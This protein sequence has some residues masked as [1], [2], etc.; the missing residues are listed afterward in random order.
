MPIIGAVLA[1]EIISASAEFSVGDWILSA[2]NYIINIQHNLDSERVNVALWENG[3][4]LVGVDRVN[5]TGSNTLRITISAD[6][7]C[8]FSGVVIIFRTQ[9]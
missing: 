7:D 2:G 4:D 1:N 6:P 8:R 5:I 9:E 3:V